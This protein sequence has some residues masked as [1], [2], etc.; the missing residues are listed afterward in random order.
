MF[1]GP[2]ALADAI[3]IGM[4]NNAGTTMSVSEASR[5]GASMAKGLESLHAAGVMHLDIK[6]AN[7]LL[8]AHGDVVLADFSI[9]RHIHSTLTARRPSQAMF[10]TANYMCAQA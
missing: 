5:I 8:D 3:L 2:V 10:G 6:P 4:W 7:V 9:S 1:L